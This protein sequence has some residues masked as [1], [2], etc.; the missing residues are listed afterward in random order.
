MLRALLPEQLPVLRDLLTTVQPPLL[1]INGA[2]CH[3]VVG[4]Q[5]QRGARSDRSGGRWL[6][7]GEWRRQAWTGFGLD[8]AGR[9]TL[10]WNLEK[11]EKPCER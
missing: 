1:I 5:L 11:G 7:M 4:S 6:L 3:G 9:Q 2:S 8:A 10:E